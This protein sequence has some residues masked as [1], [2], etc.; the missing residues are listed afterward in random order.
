[1]ADLQILETIL[2]YII[3]VSLSILIILLSPLPY[4]MKKILSKINFQFTLRDINIRFSLIIIF[5]AL[6]G[7]GSK[8]CFQCFQ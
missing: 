2:F 8:Y 1:M 4:S 5:F 6:C 7:L 3:I